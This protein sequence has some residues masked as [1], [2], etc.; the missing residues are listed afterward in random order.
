VFRHPL[1]EIFLLVSAA[2]LAAPPAHAVLDVTDVT[3]VVTIARTSVGG[4]DITA[5]L[6]VEGT[7][8]NNGTIELPSSPGNQFA[9]DEDGADLVL[10]I[11]FANEDQLNMVLPNGNYILRFNSG[12]AQVTIPYVRLSVPSPAISHP[13]PG[14]VVPPGPIEVAFTNCSICGGLGESVEAVLEDDMGGVLDEDGLSPSDDSWIPDDGMGGDL[15]LPESSLFVVRVTHTAVD[16]DDFPIDDDDDTL[17]FTS[18]FVQSD[19]VDFETG[20]APPSGRFC[21]AANHPAPPAGCHTLTDPLLHLF[22]P[23]GMVATQVDGHDVDYTVSVGESGALTGTATADF[24]DNGSNETGPA[25]IKGKLKG[26]EGE[27]ASKLSFSLVNATSKL[28]VSVA[29]EIS[30][31]GDV[32]NREQRASGTIEGL[33]IKEESSSSESPLPVAPLGWLV[34]YDLGADGAITNAVLTLE[35]GRSFPLTGTNKFNFSSNQSSVKL[36]S[37]PKG[38]SVTLKKLG[39]DDSPAPAPMAITEGQVGYRALGQSGSATLP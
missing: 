34:E 39:L 38:V 1:R 10:D 27:A 14:Q 13:D 9:L 33:K 29:D 36:Q 2:L 21:L 31:A 32:L 23:T 3:L 6:R 7:D 35:G 8:L 37:D 12:A 30:L 19:E 18:T 11:D 16:Q 4:D 28:K 26:S 25:P 15:S 5:Q 20:F 22:D 17:L 24:D